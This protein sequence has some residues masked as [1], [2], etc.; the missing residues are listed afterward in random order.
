MDEICSTPAL[1][2]TQFKCSNF[3][4]W[5]YAPE[6]HLFGPAFMDIFNIDTLKKIASKHSNILQRMNFQCYIWTRGV[7]YKAYNSVCC[8]IHITPRLVLSIRSPLS[9]T[10][11]ESGIS[12]VPLI[13]LRKKNNIPNKILILDKTLKN[14]TQKKKEDLIA[15]KKLKPE[16]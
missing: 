12:L 15:R 13:H 2:V 7:R 10:K 8:R 1:E 14:V 5:H 9:K 11:S 6:A 3:S 16:I 4:L